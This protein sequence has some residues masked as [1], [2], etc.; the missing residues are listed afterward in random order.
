MPS[1]LNLLFAVMLAALLQRAPGAP[2]QDALTY[3]QAGDTSGEEEEEVPPE[4]LRDVWDSVLG[5]SSRH[6]K[7]FED[8]FHNKLKYDF[9]D[10]YKISSLPE[11]C[12][13]SNF[14]KEACFHRLVEGLLTFTALLQHVQKEYP[15]STI[16]SDIR[17]YSS[18]VIGLI[19]QKMKHPERVTAV[20]SSQEREQQLGDIGGPDIFQRR[21][22][23]H[24]ILH[25]FCQFLI[26]CKRELKKRERSRGSNRDM[27]PISWPI[28]TR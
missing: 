5:V 7:Q 17:H 24:S 2:A 18:I 6:Q 3:S 12:P 11:R 10:N 9:L 16:P 8:E 27:A 22:A 25:R 28:S 4:P 20:S 15:S 13:T 19:Q 26:Y 21:M 14:S 23:A 1:K